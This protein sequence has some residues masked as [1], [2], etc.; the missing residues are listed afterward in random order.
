MKRV[1]FDCPPCRLQDQAKKMVACVRKMR[2]NG[3][4]TEGGALLEEEDD[5]CALHARHMRTTHGRVSC[6]RQR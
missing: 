1:L 5:V 2:E 6:T 4:Q 3:A